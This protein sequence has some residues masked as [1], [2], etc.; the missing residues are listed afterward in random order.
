MKISGRQSNK[1]VNLQNLPRFIRLLAVSPNCRII[2]KQLKLY[3]TYP[4]GCFNGRHRHATYRLPDYKVISPSKSTDLL[5]RLP[6]VRPEIKGSAHT[7]NGSLKDVCDQ[8]ETL[9]H[10]D[11]SDDTAKYELPH[12]DGRFTCSCLQE[13]FQLPAKKSA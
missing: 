1:K 5:K 2:P 9:D 10:E 11:L 6:E 7:V 8:S 4:Q 12:P 3:E 13:T